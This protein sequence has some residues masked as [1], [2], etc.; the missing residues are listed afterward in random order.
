[1]AVKLSALHAGHP[2]QPRKIPGTELKNLI[3]SMGIEHATFR[4]AA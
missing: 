4:L 2:S 1:M 3:T